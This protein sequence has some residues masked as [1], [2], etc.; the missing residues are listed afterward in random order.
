[1]CY[2]L[3]RDLHCEDKYI[4]AESKGLV[5]RCTQER[6]ATKRREGGWTPT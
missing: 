3:D 6:S 5:S 2:N 1:M 4:S